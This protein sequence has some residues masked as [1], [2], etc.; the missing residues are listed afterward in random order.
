VNS[1]SRDACSRP[2]CQPDAFGRHSWSD[3]GEGYG[4][5]P[6]PSV[7][8]DPVGPLYE[9]SD[10][11]QYGRFVTF[12]GTAS[13]SDATIDIYLDGVYFSHGNQGSGGWSSAAEYGYY[14]NGGPVTLLV[15]ATPGGYGCDSA[16]ASTTFEVLNVDPTVTI[17]VPQTVYEGAA[18]DF[19]F[20]IE[21]PGPDSFTLVVD[22]GDGQSQ[23]VAVTSA[24]TVTLPHTY[25]DDTGGPFTITATATDDDGG[26][27]RPPRPVTVINVAPS[28]HAGS[29]ASV[30]WNDS[31]SLSGCF[32][33]PGWLDTHTLAWEVVDENDAVIAQGSGANFAF[34]PG[35]LGV[36]T[37]TLTVTDDDGGVGADSV[38]I[39]ATNT[40]PLAVDD[41]VQL[42]EEDLEDVDENS[43][44]TANVL[45]NDSDPDDDPLTVIAMEAPAGALLFNWTESGAVE[46]VPP[47]DWS[48]IE[49]LTYTITDGVATATGTLVIRNVGIL[50]LDVRTAYESPYTVTDGDLVDETE[51]VFTYAPEIPFLVTASVPDDASDAYQLSVFVQDS[52]TPLYTASVGPG[53]AFH[54]VSMIAPGLA[55]LV[56]VSA[57]LVDP[58]TQQGANKQKS[59]PIVSLVWKFNQ[60]TG[61]FDLTEEHVTNWAGDFAASQAT[62]LLSQLF[63]PSG[64]NGIPALA[65]EMANATNKTIAE[66]EEII[67]ANI[68]FINDYLTGKIKVVAGELVE[69]LLYS[70]DRP[71][72]KIKIG[73]NNDLLEPIS[74]LLGEIPSALDKGANS[75]LEDGNTIGDDVGKYV[76][77]KLAAPEAILANALPNSLRDILRQFVKIDRD[78]TNSTEIEQAASALGTA[79]GDSVP[80]KEFPLIEELGVRVPLIFGEEDTIGGHVFFGVKD[81]SWENIKESTGTIA[82]EGT[83]YLTKPY[84]RPGGTVLGLVFK[85]GILRDLS[86]NDFEPQA[87]IAIEAIR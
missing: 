5:C 26:V 85:G 16:S 34:V 72:W 13:P 47:A 55:D 56:T 68:A 43:P 23:S 66:C 64:A 9:G 27:G 62:N 77:L 21:D 79:F 36:Y 42:T 10:P 63:P 22:W 76:T 69:L 25:A 49:A 24:G 40:A 20:T 67:Q 82:L 53:E 70:L 11:G 45:G 31:I 58:F 46:F 86:T 50:A 35:G 30:H 84:V 32:T 41:D 39:T 48:G 54:Q 17:G 57:Q 12:T 7:A 14:D 1:S 60:A 71:Q 52:T 61:Q 4:S 74:A 8:I 15:V 29:N 37:A 65:E 51:G 73:V 75:L 38:E 44:I 59:E 18:A 28:V 3:E 6:T 33:D 2:I 19:T 80:W 78:L 81:L 83:T 87:T